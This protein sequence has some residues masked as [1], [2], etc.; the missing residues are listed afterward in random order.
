MASSV[1]RA[2]SY[3]RISLRHKIRLHSRA[4]V[5]VSPIQNYRN[6]VLS[7]VHQVPV[8]V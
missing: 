6:Y 8:I 7:P 4:G 1:H 3:S 5:L 2:L